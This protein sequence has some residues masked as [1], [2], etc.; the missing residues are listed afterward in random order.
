MLNTEI[1]KKIND[2]PYEVS[3]FG[4]VRRDPKSKY[5][6]KAKS[7]V[8]PYVNNKG[9]LCVN[10]YK[11]SKVYKFQ[12][13]RLVAIYFVPNPN[14]YPCV[15]HIDGVKLNND[16]PNLEWCTHQQNMQHAWDTGLSNHRYI[17]CSAKRKNATSKYK[18]VWWSNE[19]KRWC[20]G[21]RVKGKRIALGRY[22]DEI[23]AAK[24]YDDYVNENNLQQYGYSTNFS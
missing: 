2:L 19:R 24:A 22:T 1:W 16:I 11:N 5:N 4:T 14:N 21:V 12:V 13:H 23:E 18:G 9:Y 8:Q 3:N 20:S 10:L 7:C 15:N 6:Q 17:N